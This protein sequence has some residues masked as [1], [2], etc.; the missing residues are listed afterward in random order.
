MGP[1]PNLASFL[2]DLAADPDRP[3]FALRTLYRRFTWT[4]GEVRGA[5]LN[6]ARLLRSRGVCPGEP[7]LLMGPAS[8][9]WVAGFFG[10]VA[11]GGVVVPLDEG[12]ATEFTRRVAE[13]V[14]ARVAIV[15]GELA[16]PIGK[17]G[18]GLIEVIPFGRFAGTHRAAAG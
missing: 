17:L 3:A 15:A 12:A 10:I 11:A 6:T 8:P 16:A 4:A 9:E 2:D 14:R 5:A 7:V 13:K 18:E 1:R